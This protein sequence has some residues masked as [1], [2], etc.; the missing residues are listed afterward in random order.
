MTDIYPHLDDPQFQRKITLK[1]E[2]RYR[3]DG[4]IEPVKEK[5]K[6]MCKKTSSFELSPHQEF[7]R[8]FISYQNPYN[9]LL[10][11]HGLGSGKT[12]SA[13]SITESL[14]MYSKYI[15]NFKKILMVASPNVQENFKLQLFDASKLTR[16]NGLWNLH[17]CVGN[18][19]LKELNIDNTQEIKREDLIYRIRKTIKDHYSFIGYG[20]FA[21]FIE[22]QLSNRNTKRLQN[23]FRSRVIVIDEIHN[24]R[25]TETS[26]DSIGK[27]IASMLNK[28]VH[29]VKG[30]KFIFLTGTPMYND[31]KEIIY[32]LNLMNL[33]DN[34]GTLQIKDVFTESGELKEGGMEKIQEKANG[35][36]SYVRGENPYVFPYM[37]TPSM[38]KDEHSSLLSIPPTLQFNNKKISP[39]QHLDLYGVALSDHQETA[40]M[41][42]I[43]VIEEKKTEDFENIDSLGYNDLMKPIQHL[44]V[45][46]PHEDEYYTGDE[47][48]QY[49]MQ[50]RE[51]L[52]PP[53]RNEFVYN[54]TPLKGMF[55]YDQIGQ[56]SSKIKSLLDQILSSKGIVL[57]YSQYING[58]LVPIAL[59]LEELG[60]KRFGEKSKTLFRDKK[61][62]LNVYNL[63]KSEDYQGKFKKATYAII[64]GE[65]ML[66]PDNNEEIY[67]LTHDNDRGQNV[68]VVLISQAGTEG[69]DLKNVRQVHVMEPWYN[70][71]RIEQIIGRAR[72]NCSHS[73]LPL[74]E[75]NFMLFLY[76]SLLKDEKRESLDNLL[77]RMAEKK[78]IKIGKVSRILKSVSVDCLLNKEQQNFAKMTETLPL[79]LSNGKKII[80]DVRDKPFSSLC[81]YSEQCEYQC[82]NHISELEQ[83]DVLTYS[84]KDTQN[85]KLEDKIK[86]LF[87]KKH[88]YNRD[89]IMHLIRSPIEELLRTLTDMTE[90]KIPVS[91]KY[92][93]L[94]YIVQIADLY[95]FQPME[96]TDPRTLLYDRT[97]PIPYH[98]KSF[99]LEEGE[100]EVDVDLDQVEV[101]TEKVKE[102]QPKPK[103]KG[104]SK[105]ILYELEQLYH[106]AKQSSEN[107]EEDWYALYSKASD[108]M[109]TNEGFTNAQLERYLIEH[110]CEQ[111]NLTKELNVLQ[112]LVSRQGQRNEFEDKINAYYEERYVVREDITAIGLLDREGT[113]NSMVIYVK[114]DH[115]WRKATPTEKNLFRDMYTFKKGPM[116]STIG[117]MG[118]CTDHTY[119]FKIKEK[120]NPDTRGSYLLIKKKSDI[121]DFLNNVVLE[122]PV[123]SKE[124][125]KTNKI[126]RTEL[127]ILSELYMRE[128]D[129]TNKERYFLSKMDYYL[130]IEKN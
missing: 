63:K 76:T 124:N 45:T 19:L 116:N 70:L 67:A 85:N 6:T 66:S 22:K 123:F 102:M 87:S 42:T 79:L 98:P 113:K 129:R 74:Q 10:L 17:G 9:S 111:M 80:Y 50:Y 52:Y 68:K 34:R 126:T 118:Y 49:V 8:K 83:E 100:V 27:K 12:C 109:K 46:Y 108:Y 43:E 105:D 77:Y 58:G 36:V 65:K 51:T 69:I 7:V 15:P 39:I 103:T 101:D 1:K 55:E 20:S 89:E 117:F 59:A 90:Q 57:V 125:T 115:S 62:D 104:K 122:K 44:L 84:Y 112:E 18:S 28:L 92:S 107:P 31:P 106:Q 53:S 13:I 61:E 3:Y 73:E 33:N 121:I 120:K 119:Q 38:Y 21:N 5:S 35:Y 16:V 75:R 128:L 114:T 93:K 24:I 11:Y 94:G 88:V 95:L 56:Y 127:T 82:R 23:M 78:S 99:V 81:D 37:I 48:L 47:G 2:F 91:D 130:Y 29:Y 4:T 40:Y 60:F 72:R 97:R 71:N 30:I 96:L 86:A 25:I 41:K 64:S 14:R 26:S 32:L 54:D 110:L